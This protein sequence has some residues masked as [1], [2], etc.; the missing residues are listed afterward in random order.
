MIG[1]NPSVE[2]GEKTLVKLQPRQTQ[3]E[4][5]KNKGGSHTSHLEEQ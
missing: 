3:K 5:H 4:S 2:V 1:L